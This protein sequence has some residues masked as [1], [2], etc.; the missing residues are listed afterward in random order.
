MRTENA[1]F[2]ISISALIKVL[3]KRRLMAQSVKKMGGGS[4]LQEGAEWRLTSP[5]DATN[6]VGQAYSGD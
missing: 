2:R 5:G 1:Y 6:M 3:A 4:Q